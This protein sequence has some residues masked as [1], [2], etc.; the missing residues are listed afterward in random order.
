ML[1]RLVLILSLLP[2][3]GA[4]AH[5]GTRVYPIYE[6]P[7]ADIP[8][9]HD[10]SLEDW[11]D[12]LGYPNLTH[13]DFTGHPTIGGDPTAVHTGPQKLGQ[14]SSA[15][16]G[17]AS[18]TDPP[19]IHSDHPKTEDVRRRSHLLRPNPLNNPTPQGPPATEPQPHQLHPP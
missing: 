13:A 16:P 19:K 18:R 7:S 9:I 15:A 10:G 11:E 5:L 8:D 4:N 14:R 6:I 3:S 1:V 17:L 2:L 12:A